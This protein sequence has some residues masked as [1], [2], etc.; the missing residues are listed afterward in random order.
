MLV[1]CAG[2]EA[3]RESVLLVEGAARREGCLSFGRALDIVYRFASCVCRCRSRLRQEHS[4]L[5]PRAPSVVEGIHHGPE[6][7]GSRRPA[8]P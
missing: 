3:C 1:G 6:A 2:R 4:Q 7:R 8:T 5:G